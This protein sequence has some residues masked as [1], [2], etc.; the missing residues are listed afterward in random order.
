MTPERFTE[1][2]ILIAGRFWKSKLPSMTGKSRSYVWEYSSGKRKIPNSVAI[3][4]EAL[5]KNIGKPIK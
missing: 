1:L 2:A 3:L 4:M 5:A